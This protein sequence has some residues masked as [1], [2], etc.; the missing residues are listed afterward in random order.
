MPAERRLDR[1]GGPIERQ[2]EH[3]FGQL[4]RQVLALHHPEIDR[5][6]ILLGDGC[7]DL[8]PIL[9][10]IERG[11]GLFRLLLRRRQN[12]LHIALLG[13]LELV[14]PLFVLFADFVLR[15]VAGLDDF[16]GREAPHREGAVFRGA[17]QIGMRFVEFRQVGVARL[18]DILHARNRKSDDVGEPL[19]SAITIESFD[20]RA[21]QRDAGRDRLQEIR[22]RQIAVQTGNQ[23][24]LGQPVHD[25]HLVEQAAVEPPVWTPECRIVV[26]RAADNLVRGFEPQPRRLLVEQVAID[27]LCEQVVDDPELLDLLL[28]DGA[29]ELSAE[30]FEGRLQ[31]PLQIVRTDIVV[32]YRGDDGFRRVPLEVVGAGI[33]P[34]EAERDDQK[35]EQD[36]DDD[37]AR[38]GA[39]RLQHRRANV[40]V[41]VIVQRDV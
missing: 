34:P 7:G 40:I 2:L 22:A 25:Q 10:G 37:R 24:I 28:V 3:D 30:P 31:Y 1:I 38:S 16:L 13:C 14:L 11:R 32:A 5:L 20:D 19:L 29:A 33:D 35:P 36:L 17:E 23:L 27:Q 21:R 15:N 26:D 18:A 41:E 9:P 8:L 39:D 12:L 4:L 6:R